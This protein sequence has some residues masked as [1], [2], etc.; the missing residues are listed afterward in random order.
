MMFTYVRRIL[1]PFR[2]FS[3]KTIKSEELP[4]SA[5]NIARSFAITGSIAATTFK[6]INN[7]RTQKAGILSLNARK[8]IN[9]HLIWNT[10]WRLQWGSLFFITWLILVRIWISQMYFAHTPYLSVFSPNAGKCGPEK[11]PYLDTFH[12]VSNII[13]S[14]LGIV[15]TTILALMLCPKILSW[16]CQHVTWVTAFMQ[17]YF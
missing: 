8:W 17:N 9:L 2:S 14:F 10:I 12:A 4:Y 16:I 11:N 6:F 5:F 7:A 15:L 13:K 1:I 3:S